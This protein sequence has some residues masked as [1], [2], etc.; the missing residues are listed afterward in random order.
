[1]ISH[2]ARLTTSRSAVPVAIDTT[3]LSKVIS[4][5]LRDIIFR[6]RSKRFEVRSGH[7]IDVFPLS[8]LPE[9]LSITGEFLQKLKIKI[10]KLKNTGL[11]C[12]G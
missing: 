3:D 7:A 1:M 9:K 11:Y 5:N 10:K 4:V 12:L 6:Y 2:Q 8:V